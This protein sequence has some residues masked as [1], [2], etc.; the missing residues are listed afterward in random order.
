[1]ALVRSLTRDARSTSRPHP[2]E[3]D[4]RWQVIVG[5]HGASLFQLSTYGS[6]G[7]ESE[8][9]VSQTIQLDRDMA[10]QLVARLRETFDLQ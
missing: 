7:R 6:D 1:M 2:T 9:K 8:P 5:P 10:A 4:C 3:V